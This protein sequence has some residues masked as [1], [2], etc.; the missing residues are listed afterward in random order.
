MQVKVREMAAEEMPPEVA[1]LRGMQYE[2]APPEDVDDYLGDEWVLEQKF[3]GVR[4]IVKAWHGQVRFCHGGGGALRHAAS[5]CLLPALEHD[6]LTLA[7]SLAPGEA[8]VLD[9]EMLLSG[10]YVVYDVPLFV[11]ADGVGMRPTQPRD[12]RRGFLES[13]F[14]QWAP[15]PLVVLAREARTPAEK[16]A[17][18]ERLE[19]EGTE[20]AVAKRVDAP[21]A[22]DGARVRD[23]V[24]LKFQKTVDALVVARDVGGKNAHLAVHADEIPDDLLAFLP[25]GTPVRRI[26]ACSMIGKPDARPG[27]VVEVRYLYATEGLILYQPSLLR[28]RTD[29]AA[30]DCR[31]EQ[32]RPVSKEVV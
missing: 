15:G 7:R 2:W 21:Y 4:M 5:L 12:L 29:K 6:M 9:G 19:A 10:H 13:V 16:L 26:G 22:A 20:G 8:L 28:V 17:L 25:D 32:L 30:V 11:Q 23:V 24:K 3:D 27:E 18:M 14:E 31:I 1:E